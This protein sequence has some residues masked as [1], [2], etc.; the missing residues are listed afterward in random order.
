MTTAIVSAPVAPPGP[1]AV[2]SFGEAVERAL[3]RGDFAQVPP[4]DRTRYVGA[5]CQS[6]GLNPLTRPFDWLTDKKGKVVLYARKEATEQLRKLHNVTLEIVSERLDGDL[7]HVHVRAS[8]PVVLASG[9]TSKVHVR[10]DDDVGVVCLPQKASAED[11]ANACMKAVTKAKRRAT[12]SICGLGLPDESEVESFATEAP[13]TA[14]EERP[15]LP[16]PSTNGH[17]NGHAATATTTERAG[18]AA[19]AELKRLKQE[20]QIT[21]E[22]WKKALAKRGVTTARELSAGQVEEMIAN[23][24]SRQAAAVARQMQEALAPDGLPAPPREPQF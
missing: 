19:L 20:L 21:G 23:L 14:R 12:L 10:T 5:V 15:A 13:T 7:Y 24:R 8:M 2:A 9:K 3:V 22:A 6:L 11:R 18:E 17:A 16:A 4:E 1:P